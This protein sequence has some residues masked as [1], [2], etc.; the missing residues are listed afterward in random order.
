MQII[1]SSVS[2]LTKLLDNDYSDKRYRRSCCIIK[3][4]VDDSMLLCN[5][6]T[7]ELVLLTETEYSAFCNYDKIDASSYYELV[8]HGF[9]VPIDYDEIKIVQQLRNILIHRTPKE[10]RNYNILTTTCCNARCFYCYEQGLTPISMSEDTAS[11]LIEFIVAKSS[12][13]SIE[14]NWFGGEPTLGMDRIDQICD[15]LSKRGIVYRSS[16]ISNGYLFSKDVAVKS[17]QKWN[18]DRIQIT[19]DGTEHVYNAIKAYVAINDNPYRRVIQN[20]H[21][22]L[23]EGVKVNIRINLGL[24]NRNNILDLINELAVEF[25]GET[26]LQVYIG[27]LR[28]KYKNNERAELE[29]YADDLSLL[30]EDKGLKKRKKALPMLTLYNCMADKPN[31]IQCTPD[32]ILSKCENEIYTSRVGSL[33]EGVTDKEECIRWKNNKYYPEC[34]NCPLIP[35]CI[36]LTNCTPEIHYCR[37]TEKLKRIKD[38]KAEMKLRYLKYKSN[39]I[40]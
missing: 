8:K 28:E 36:L 23:N 3:H 25:R 16:M 12:G 6:I 39:I 22:L 5:T 10:I 20:I 27:I 4:N 40:S 35:T 15:D 14:I 9:L 7:G 32:G 18:L 2:G 30:L 26:K 13:K 33:S 21:Y 29:E 1:S 34:K 11:Q 19:L 31:H 38:Y 24:H 37:N 17:V